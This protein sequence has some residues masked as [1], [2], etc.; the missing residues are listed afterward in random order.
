MKKAI[1]LFLVVLALTAN[2]IDV[3]D[4]AGNWRMSVAAT[5]WFR[6]EKA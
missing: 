3:I 4:L 2:A 5:W 1:S 6:K